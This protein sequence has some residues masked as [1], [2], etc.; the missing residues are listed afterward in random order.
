MGKCKDN[1]III[2]SD[3]DEI[4]NPEILELDDIALRSDS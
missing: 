1:D 3:L 2:C 4:L